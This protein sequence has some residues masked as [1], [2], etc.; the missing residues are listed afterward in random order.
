MAVATE[1]RIAAT[2]KGVTRNMAQS[3]RGDM[4]WCSFCSHGREGVDISL[5]AML[6]YIFKRIQILER[7]PVPSLISPVYIWSVLHG[8]WTDP[9]GGLS[10]HW[11]F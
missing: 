3:E 11:D 8:Y 6:P 7:S 5:I 4:M 9:V 2:V 1:Q 10:P